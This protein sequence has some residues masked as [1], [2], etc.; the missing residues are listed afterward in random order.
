MKIEQEEALRAAVR[1]LRL[2]E[3]Y[4]SVQPKPDAAMGWGG[5]MMTWNELRM[6]ATSTAHQLVQTFGDDVKKLAS[7]TP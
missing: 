2:L 6:H 5:G 1:T 4:M 3:G 7:E